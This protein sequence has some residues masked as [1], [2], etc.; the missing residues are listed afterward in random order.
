MCYAPADVCLRMLTYANGRM[1]TSAANATST[2]VLARVTE[3]EGGLLAGKHADRVR[4][5]L[6]V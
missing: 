2:T 1:L 3:A 6:R 5:E 4:V